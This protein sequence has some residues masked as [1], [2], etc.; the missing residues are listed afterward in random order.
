[1]NEEK[2][3]VKTF[4]L[5]PAVAELVERAA[6]QSGF[7]EADIVERC[8]IDRLDAVLREQRVREAFLKTDSAVEALVKEV[9]KRERAPYGGASEAA[10][11][12]AA[13]ETTTEGSSSALAGKADLTPPQQN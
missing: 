8:L 3:R 7:S 5:S 1:M 10:A 2:K 13:E 6:E 4:R 11:A 12:R 9:R